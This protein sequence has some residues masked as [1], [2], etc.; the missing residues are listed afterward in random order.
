M[1]GFSPKL[2]LQQGNVD[3]IGLNTTFEEVVK[4]NIK[5][6][7]LT[8]PG[9]KIMDPNFGVG[10]LGYLFEQNTENTFESI[11][12]KI[13]EQIR[14][15]YPFVEIINLNVSPHGDSQFKPHT[16]SVKLEYVILSSSLKDALE[17]VLD[18]PDF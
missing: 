1:P 16:L 9:E 10:L 14:I 13:I 11:K 8:N 18:I 3:G 4:Q 15:Y 6:I 5:M 7:L 12:I 17:I 2:P